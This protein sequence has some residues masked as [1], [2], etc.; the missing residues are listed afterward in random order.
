MY[1]PKCGAGNLNSARTCSS[2]GHALTNSPATKAAPHPKR[3]KMAVSSFLLGILGS[4]FSVLIL[5]QSK[6]PGSTVF[7]ILHLL[8]SFL[9]GIAIIL[10]IVGLVII[11]RSRGQMKGRSLAVAGIAVPAIMLFVLLKWPPVW[12]SGPHGPRFTQKH[13]FHMI[14]VS[15]EMFRAEFDGYPPSDALD[16]ISRQY[17]G[18]M[19]LAEALMGQNVKGVYPYLKGFHPDSIFRSDGQDGFGRDLYPVNP[20]DDNLKARTEPYLPLDR[21]YAYELQDLYA[22]T[23]GFKKDSIV[24]CDVYSRVRHRGTGKRV[25]MPVLYYKA[26]TSK[27]AHSLDNP[28][29]PNNIY[30]YRD[31]HTLVGLGVP[32]DP[33]E[34][35]PLFTDP[36]IFYK[37]TSDYKATAQSKPYRAY[38]FI[39]ISAG[40]DGLY[41]TKDDIV[42]SAIRWR[43]K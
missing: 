30:N 31:N 29:D 8:F 43:P 35:H 32:W 22:N 23:A 11:V 34:K 12:R 37:M 6:M 1:C 5:M 2:C 42:N 17:C 16:P 27:T 19:K 9:G 41:G 26:D 21:A 10:G 18:A 3:S 36:E 7:V 15:L 14:D 33:N 20:P 38:S 24:L 40:Y 28:D 25:G 4:L 39:L 13:Q